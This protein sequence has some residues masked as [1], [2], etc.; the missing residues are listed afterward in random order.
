MG[1]NF[2]T[3]TVTLYV[4]HKLT[5]TIQKLVAQELLKQL[6]ATDITRS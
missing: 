5:A 3:T 6:I 4:Y 2:L 1:H